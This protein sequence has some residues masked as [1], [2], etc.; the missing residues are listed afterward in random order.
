[1]R[2]KNPIAIPESLKANEYLQVLTTVNDERK[3]RE[4]SRTLLETRLAAC[5]QILGPIASSCWWKGKIIHA[6]EWMCLAIA[7]TDDYKEIEGIIENSHPYEVPE[8]LAV[9]V[10]FGNSA[11]LNWISE[12]TA[13][14]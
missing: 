10:Y 13:P 5:V 11:Y 8:I 6:N 2:L 12:E 7:R 9:P 4:I 14:R 1:M 3:A